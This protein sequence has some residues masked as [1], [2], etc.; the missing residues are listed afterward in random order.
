V[1]AVFEQHVELMAM[2]QGHHERSRYPRDE[3]MYRLLRRAHGSVHP[4]LFI[5]CIKRLDEAFGLAAIPE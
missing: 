5:A 2:C 4:E 1:E 3:L